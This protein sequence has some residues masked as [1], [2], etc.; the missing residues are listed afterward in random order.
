MLRHRD[1]LRQFLYAAH[2]LFTLA[3][4]F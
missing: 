4:T 1:L 2:R 3:S